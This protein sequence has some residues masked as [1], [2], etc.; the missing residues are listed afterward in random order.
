H[1]GHPYFDEL[2]TRKLDEAFVRRERDAPGDLVALLPGSRTQEVRANFPSQLAAA[3]RVLREAPETRFAVA[4]F[5]PAHAERCRAAIAAAGFAEGREPRVF[6]GKTPELIEAATCCLAVSG[7]VSLELLYHAKPTAIV[8]R[9]SRLAYSLQARFRRVPYITLVNLLTAPE[10]FPDQVVVYE[11]DDP[12]HAHAL[13][14]EYLSV[15]DPSADLAHHALEWLRDPQARDA[16]RERMRTLRQRVG[17]PGA[18][19][20]AAEYVLQTMGRVSCDLVAA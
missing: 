8:Y 7:S 11:R 20:R 5:K 3:K 9:V 16:L 17:A 18:S 6:V 19:N 1:V 14:P 2:S 10:L 4:A 12:R 15:D 13:M